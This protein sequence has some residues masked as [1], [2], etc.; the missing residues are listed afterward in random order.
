MAVQEDILFRITDIVESVG[1]RWAIPTQLSYRSPL[2]LVSE[3]KTS[4]A[5][6]IV[7][8]WRDNNGNAF[9]DFPASRIAEMRGTL[10]YPEENR[11]GVHQ[12]SVGPPHPIKTAV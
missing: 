2:P 7:Q 4:Q 9:P 6:R 3:E 1:A 8:Q 5:E 10:A 11:A 12:E